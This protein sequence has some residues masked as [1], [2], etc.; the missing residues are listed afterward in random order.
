MSD[1]VL[2]RRIGEL[3]QAVR[4]ERERSAA[5]LKRCE[6][7]EQTARRA[8]GFAAGFRREQIGNEADAQSE[9]AR[10]VGNDLPVAQI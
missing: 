1:S 5:L 7:L 9:R 6:L 4:R 2:V 8:Y 3:E 10:Q